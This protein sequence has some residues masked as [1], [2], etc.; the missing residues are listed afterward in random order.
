MND[1]RGMILK[2][3]VPGVSRVTAVS[4]ADGLLRDPGVFRAIEGRGFSL[5]QFE[6][7]ISFRFDYETRFRPRW[8]GGE[9]VEL[10]V[11]FKPRECE[12]ETLPADVLVQAQRR[13]FTLKDIFPK[14]SYGIVSQLET[15]HFDALHSA[16]AQ[17][18]ANPLGDVLTKDFVLQHV[19]GI[20]PSIVTKESD[21]LWTLFQKHYSKINVPK[22][23]DDHLVSV[24]RQRS[25]FA[26]WPLET[27]VRERTAF[28]EFLDERWPIF[29]RRTKGGTLVVKEEPPKL[30]YPGPEVLPFNHNDVRIFV[31]NLFEDGILT[32]VSWDWN[33]AL[34]ETWIRVGLSGERSDNLELRFDELGKHLLKSCPD[35]NA[36]PQ[37]WLAFAAR[38][39]QAN[40]LWTK[41][42]QTVREKYKTQFPQ[43]RGFVNEQ[44]SAWLATGYAGLFNYPAISPLMVHHL[45]GY[46]AHRLAKSDAQ[47]L[48]FL[49]IDGLAM[50]QW[51]AVKEALRELGFAGAFEER[52][53]FAWIPSITPISR[54]AAYAGKIPR[55]FAESVTQTDRD[56]SR[57]RQF[58][59]DRGLTSAEVGFLAVR[60]DAGDES[61]GAEIV[62]NRLR[63]L[64]VTLFKVDKIMHGM[65]L[66]STGMIG[67]VQTWI[68]Q[69][70]LKSLLERLMAEGFE[71]IVSA[72]HG[73]IEAVGVGSP[74]EGVLAEKRGERCRIYLETV[75]RQNGLATIP[76]AIGWDHT[77]LPDDFH[78]LL[79]P[80]GKA[81]TQDGLVV[82]CHG[83]ASLEEVVIPFVRIERVS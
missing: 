16:Q 50:D 26:S 6:D 49:L 22:V 19:F 60:G 64:G 53:L 34:P 68:E 21:L 76:G 35:T 65:Q 32:P 36:P 18:A 17:Y 15:V 33:E 80:Y 38:Y 10:A 74:K 59:S 71:I 56:E 7:S 48:A 47:R 9:H 30:K 43:L 70:F 25:L 58:W 46:M 81:F 37:A 1:W 12:F 41:I 8:D 82:V 5:L 67:Q 72:D 51:L 14:L 2:H 69:G 79:A 39:A 40:L 61:A 42:G 23:L 27:L 66:G 13:S 63:V 62:T 77:G 52:A 3:F 20:V 54:Q 28:W 44:F 55:Y 4:D 57:W 31:D 75:L 83:G 78:S 24:L 45:P 29:V 11:V 73:N